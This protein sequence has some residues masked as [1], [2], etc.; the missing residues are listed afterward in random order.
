MLSFDFFVANA[1]LIF[2]EKQPSDRDRALFFFGGVAFP[3]SFDVFIIVR[4]MYLLGR[5]P[6]HN[7]A[8]S[9]QKSI[10]FLLLFYYFILDFLAEVV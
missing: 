2:F 6:T 3:E 7:D 9:Q 5:Q 4:I 1:F 8:N 10:T